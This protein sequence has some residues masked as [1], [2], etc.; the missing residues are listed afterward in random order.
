MK[1]ISDAEF[2]KEVLQSPVPVLVDFWAPWCG[3]CR[4]LA[5]VLD[6]LADKQGEALRIVKINIDE[7]AQ[8]AAAM[9]VRSIPT[10]ALFKDGQFCE[11]TLGAKRLEELEEFVQ[12]NT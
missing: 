1:N 2:E 8:V 5:P 4:M 12:R 10:L 6:K 11:M 7:N 3:P 9:S